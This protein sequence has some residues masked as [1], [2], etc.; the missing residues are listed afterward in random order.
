MIGGIQSLKNQPQ[1]EK[2]GSVT[3]LAFYPKYSGDFLVG[4]TTPFIPETEVP[5]FMK[6][7][8]LFEKGKI[9]SIEIKN[10]I[11]M[12]PMGIVGLVGYKG[13]FTDRVI[14]YYERRAIGETGL[15]TTGLCLVNSKIVF[16][17]FLG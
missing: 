8:Y 16:F 2:I 3:K 9:G 17:P 14:D 6:Y 10:R 7:P 1:I 15:I 13:T 12:A 5:L 4:N 11:V